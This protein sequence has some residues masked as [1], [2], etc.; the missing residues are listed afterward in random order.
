MKFILLTWEEVFIFFMIQSITIDLKGL[1]DFYLLW[2]VENSNNNK[3]ETT[4]I[5]SIFLLFTS[6]KSSRPSIFLSNKDVSYSFFE[7]GK[8]EIQRLE[9]EFTLMISFLI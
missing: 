5:G 3:P 8:T 2:L 9:P 6:I 1:R 4:N 7:D